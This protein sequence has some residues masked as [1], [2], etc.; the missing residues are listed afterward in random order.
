MA[1]LGDFGSGGTCG[2][3]LAGLFAWGEGH[4]HGAQLG[5]V[6]ANATS[7]RGAQV[8]GVLARATGRV[9]G[10]Q[11]AAVVVA[12]DLTGGQLGAVSIARDLEGLQAGALSIARDGSGFQ[13]GALSLARDLHGLQAGAVSIARNVRGLQLGAVNVAT[14]SEGVQLGVV[15][16]A[17]DADAPLGLVNVIRNGRLHV[18]GF[19][20][21]YPGFAA[22][23]VV[24]G[25]RYTHAPSRGLACGVTL[26]G[27]RG[28]SSWSAW[29]ATSGSAI[30]PSRTSTC[31]I[32]RSRRLRF[33]TL[34][35]WRSS[36][37]SRVSR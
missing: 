37:S 11:S 20:L 16:V 27:W 33:K 26:A 3:H 17:D 4:V 10:F 22:A 7:I 13:L 36:A 28:R 14:R 12:S 21:D 2:L 8:S 18:D 6:V 19:A 15:N 30:P 9:E 32:T 25:G 29:A 31:S 34:R 1:L 5:G 24:H 35:T 23:L